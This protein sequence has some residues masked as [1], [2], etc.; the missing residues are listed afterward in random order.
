VSLDI[1]SWSVSTVVPTCDVDKTRCTA[2]C[3]KTTLESTDVT[4]A[5]TVS[6]SLET[7]SMR[8]TVPTPDVKKTVG[9][10]SHCQQAKDTSKSALLTSRKDEGSSGLKQATAVSTA[11]SSS[12]VL[13][14]VPTC[15]VKKTAGTVTPLTTMLKS[16][17]MDKKPAKKK[18]IRNTHQ[19]RTKVQCQQSLSSRT[20]SCKRRHSSQAKDTSASLTSRSDEGSSELEQA[21]GIAI[22][23]ALTTS[24]SSVVTCVPTR[25]VDKTVTPSTATLTSTNVT[26]ASVVSSS[27]QTSSVTLMSTTT[28]TVTLQSSSVS[29]CQQLSTDVTTTCLSGISSGVSLTSA[30]LVSTSAS[31]GGEGL[32]VDQ[33]SLSSSASTSAA[34]VSTCVSV[35]GEGLAV[36]HLSLPSSASTLAALVSTSASVGGEGLAVDQLSLPSSAS[37]SVSADVTSASVSGLQ[38]VSHDVAVTK[39]ATSH[40]R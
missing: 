38:D 29:A 33:L 1:S 5:S 11:A 6:S 3:L 36:D 8:L 39:V 31:V 40:I 17:S 19:R 14:V 2:T 10:A 7:S 23:V 34:L 15:A 30:A 24:S 4:G 12:S 20:T 16:T 21:I 26:E 27:L 13:T 9:T 22:S 37:S 28:N 18:Q 32:A 25:D 35:G